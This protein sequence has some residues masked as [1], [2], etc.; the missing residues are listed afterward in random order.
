MGKLKRFNTFFF[1]SCLQN[2]SLC[3]PVYNQRNL[4][5]TCQ[6]MTVI[7]H[8]MEANSTEVFQNGNTFT[9][10]LPQLFFI[11]ANRNMI[12]IQLLKSNIYIITAVCCMKSIL[13]CDRQNTQAISVFHLPDNVCTVLASAESHNAV[14]G[15]SCFLR[16]FLRLLHLLCKNTLSFFFI[17]QKLFMLLIKIAVIAYAPFIKPDFR[18]IFGKSAFFTIL[19]KFL[20][21][22]AKRLSIIMTTSS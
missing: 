10:H 1:Q 8:I 9:V 2:L 14:I 20:L 11:H 17:F 22:T 19:H 3:P 21:F 18:I 16:L 4:K 15:S 12:H 7:M 5:F 6:Y 13:K